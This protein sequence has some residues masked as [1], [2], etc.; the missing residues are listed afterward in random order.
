MV[1]HVGLMCLQHAAL[2]HL[3][4]VSKEADSK[5][6]VRPG[7]T[8]WIGTW[9]WTTQAMNHHHPASPPW[10]HH[11]YRPPHLPYT[12]HFLHFSCIPHLLCLLKI[13]CPPTLLGHLTIP[14][15]PILILHVTS[16]A[17]RTHLL[18]LPCQ[19]QPP[20][21]P[22]MHQSPGQ[23]RSRIQRLLDYG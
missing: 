23:M 10:F 11:V 6:T 20:L 13:P 15:C 5:A 18:H 8:T 1:A 19:F 4:D 2:W 22:C 9:T 17:H 12:S 21:T 7:I 3:S 14:T 16:P